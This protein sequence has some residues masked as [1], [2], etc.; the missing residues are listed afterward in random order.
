MPSVILRTFTRHHWTSENIAQRSP[1]IGS[2]VI[3]SENGRERKDNKVK[4]NF[5]QLSKII[6]SIYL[7]YRYSKMSYFHVIFL[8][9][10]KSLNVNMLTTTTFH[11]LSLFQLLLQNIHHQLNEGIHYMFLLCYRQARQQSSLQVDQQYLKRNIVNITT[12]IS[13][14]LN[15]DGNKKHFLTGRF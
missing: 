4:H 15:S 7:W 2:D 8:T 14:P 11:K 3:F 13:L 12:K 6:D 10:P 1:T 9:S 5:W